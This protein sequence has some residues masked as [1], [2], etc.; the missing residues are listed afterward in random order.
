MALAH[1]PR[2]ITDG[3]VLCLD[4]GNTKSY[5]GSGTTWKDISG[6]GNDGTLT[7]GPT[8]NS[9]NGGSLVFD[10]TNDYVTGETPYSPTASQPLTLSVWFYNEGQ[11]GNRGIC[12][13]INSSTQ[14]TGSVRMINIRSSNAVYFWGNSADF[15]PTNFISEENS[16]TNAVFTVDA[17]KKI[18]AY[19][20]GIFNED[21][22][23]SSLSNTNALNYDIGVRRYF[24][25]YF[26]GNISQVSIYNKALTASEVQ[27]N[28]N[29]LKGR[30]GL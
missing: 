15:N 4:A 8:Y 28:Y 3:L 17:A 1:S 26:N 23:I 20:N 18:T 13:I 19:K 14:P 7:N 10:G 22:T 9:T 6:K 11:S 25:E 12:G 16:W 29:A 2:I 24:G 30:Y 21:S 5:P 27:Q